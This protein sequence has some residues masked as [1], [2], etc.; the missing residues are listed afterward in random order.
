MKSI[1][2]HGVK[3]SD[4]SKVLDSFFWEMIKKN[5]S[6]FQVITGNSEKMKNIVIELCDEYGFEAEEDPSNGGSLTIFC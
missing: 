1:D 3:H 4:V 6:Y 5:V 2:L